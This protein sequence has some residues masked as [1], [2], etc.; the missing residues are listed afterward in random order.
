MAKQTI[1]SGMKIENKDSRAKKGVWKRRFVLAISFGVLCTLL[2]WLIVAL[3]LGS[4]DSPLSHRL[5][6]PPLFAGSTA[7]DQCRNNNV[8]DGQIKQRNWRNVMQFS[9]QKRT[10]QRK[11]CGHILLLSHPRQGSTWFLDCVE[12]CAFSNRYNGTFGKLN[13][14]SELWNVAQKGGPLTN[15]SATLAVEFLTSVMSLKIFSTPWEVYPHGV[16]QVVL[17]ASKRGIPIVILNRRPRDAY[18]SFER[19]RARNLWNENT[20]SPSGSD[21]D[22]VEGK[23]FNLDS[24]QNDVINEKKLLNSESFRN[25]KEFRMK[26]YERVQAFLKKENIPYDEVDYDDIKAQPTIVLPVANCIV[27]NC[28]S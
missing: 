18:L 3:S 9:S 26:H 4:R 8:D 1:I 25:F 27:C 2:L 19:A 12:G 5:S 15:I 6:V 16:R 11:K 13:A 28:N 17:N 24:S 22:S 23:D 21:F 10:Q 7:F 20:Y 14:F